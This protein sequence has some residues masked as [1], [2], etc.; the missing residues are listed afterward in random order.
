MKYYYAIVHCNNKKTA[1]FLYDEYNGYEFENT[2][3]RLNMSFVP[4]DII[5]EQE[6]KQEANEVPEDY[7]FNFNR[8]NRA[9][10]HSDVKLTWD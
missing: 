7:E 10:G 1:L 6:L 5:F 8:I 4:D 9:V 2:N 3:I